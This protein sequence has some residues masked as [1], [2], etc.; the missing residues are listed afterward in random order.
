MSEPKVLLSGLAFGE[1]PRWDGSRLLVCDWA[2]S[3]LLAVDEAGASEVVA[4]VHSFPFCIAT[5]SDGSVLIVSSADRRLERLDADGTRSNGADLGAI[6][7]FPWN[8][9][10]VDPQGVAFVNNIGFDFPMGEVGP[11]FIVAVTPDGSA[12]VVAD[13]L[14]FPNG[15]VVTP[16]GSTLIVAESYA[17]RLTAFDIG[18]EGALA[19]RRVWA[20]LGDAA[21]DGICLDEAGAVWYA[22]VPNRNCVRVAEGGEVL[23]V[24]EL[25]RGCFSCALGGADGRTLFIVATEWNGPDAIARGERSGQVV[26][27]RVE[28]GAAPVV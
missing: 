24:V 12:R 7:E 22:D 9:I 4:Q 11:G 1:S 14:A 26:T 28:V 8:E 18:E 13:D 3:E 17:G 20:D 19:N 23:Q 27:V 10:A 16:D 21:P 25:D 6:S 15:M 5:R 2:A